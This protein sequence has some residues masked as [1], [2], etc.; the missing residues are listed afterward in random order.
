MKIAAK[1][2]LFGE[3]AILKGGDALAIP[4]PDFSGELS[5]EVHTR[6][7][8]SNSNIASFVNHLKKIKDALLVFDMDFFRLHKDVAAGLWF[9]SNIPENAGL[10]SSGA[11]VASVAAKYG[12]T[13]TSKLLALKHDLALMEACFHGNSSG[14]DPLVSYLNSGVLVKNNDVLACEFEPDWDEVSLVPVEGAGKTG[15]LVDIFQNRLLDADYERVF[16]NAYIPIQNA[17]IDSVVGGRI[18]K[19]RDQ[20]FEL[21]AMQLSLFSEMIPATI[22]PMWK[23]GLRTKQFALKLCG[24]G[25]GGYVIR[26]N[27]QQ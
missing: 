23:E 2:L 1:L 19:T 24:S 26:F 18:E 21:S 14:I 25:G 8:T 15:N 5:M 12:F 20:L 16:R 3:Y 6:Q 10:G 17:I 13:K 4:L 7:M 27:F 9:Q 11:L 22:L